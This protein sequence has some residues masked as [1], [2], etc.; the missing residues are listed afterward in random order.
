MVRLT[1]VI[2]RLESRKI[3]V[4]GDLMLDSYTFGKVRRISPEAPVAVVQVTHEESRP[5]GAGN[6]ALNL[7][8]LGANVVLLSRIGLDE[9]GTILRDAL[10]K[11]GIDISGLFTQ[12]EFETPMKNRVIADNQQ[13]VRVD[14]ERTTYL[15]EML[16]QHIIETLPSLMKDID[17]VAISDYGKGLLSR[18][19][20]S[21]IIEQAKAAGVPVITDPKGVEFSK[22]SGSTVIK[23]NLSEAYAAAGLPSEVSLELVAQRVLEVSNADMLMITRSEAGISIFQRN[24]ERL[25]FP[26]KVQEIK[27]VTGAGDTVLA[28][29]T[30]AIA[31]DLSIDVASQLCNV[32][33]SI[34]IERIGCARVNLSD[35]LR[36]LL[37]LDVENKVFDEEHLYVLRETLREGDFSLL[38]LSSKQGM[39]SVSFAA[40]QSL[41][42]KTDRDLVVYLLD[43]EPTEDFV[44]LLISIRDIKFIIIKGENLSSLCESIQ[45]SEIFAVSNR[46][47]VELPTVSSLLEFVSES[48]EV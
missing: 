2:S 33:A 15:S 32:A 46:K 12:K 36:R 34:A 13:I 48:T 26:V 19:L 11:E 16:E 40:I 4:A 21:A 6:V 17:A 3:L 8:S 43:T 42:R 28:M 27:D 20:L 44:N 7:V 45:P 22:Y 38:G 9:S 41:S 35:L 18:T 14:Y 1:N 23:P 30:Y 5:G 39:D 29:L 24:E 37:E 25:D 31:N 10:K 47:L